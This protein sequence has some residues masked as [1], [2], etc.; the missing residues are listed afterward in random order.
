MKQASNEVCQ[1]LSKHYNISNNLEKATRF[2]N[3][4]LLLSPIFVNFLL[5]QFKKNYEKNLG[6]SNKFC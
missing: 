2:G 4:L 5:I 3:I 1:A 6:Y